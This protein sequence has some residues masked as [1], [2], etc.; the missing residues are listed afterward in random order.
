MSTTTVWLA[1]HGE[2][3]NPGNVLYGR[4]PR[5]RL[6]PRGQAEAQRIADFVAQRPLA[7]VYS[8]PMLRARKTADRILRGH[9]ELRRVRLD[10]DLQ[11]VRT[12]WQGEPLASLEEIDWDFYANPRHCTDES[13]E[14]INAR[15]QRWLKRVL[16]RHA[17]EEVVGVSHG[18]PILILTGVLRGLPLQQQHL[19]PRP[20]IHTGALYRLQFAADGS[21]LDV[22]LLP[23]DLHPEESDEAAA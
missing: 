16:R 6:T 10:V 18:D 15:M 21:C 1:R 19:F 17:G 4:L 14:T 2:V 11:E 8:S 7:A 13:L 3:H 22:Q 12:G 9:S 20:Y 23:Q 5:M